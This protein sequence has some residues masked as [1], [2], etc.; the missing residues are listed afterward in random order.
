MLSTL[1][2]LAY[3]DVP[4]VSVPDAGMRIAPGDTAVLRAILSNVDAP[5][6][7]FALTYEAPRFL[8][9]V[10]PIAE[11]SLEAG[12]VRAL[13]LPVRIDASAPPGPTALGVTM[14]PPSGESV[15]WEIPFTVGERTSGRLDVG[16]VPSEPIFDVFEAVV[17]VRNEGNVRTAFEVQAS[18]VR[19]I[20]LFLEPSRLVLEPDES[21][22]VRMRGRRGGRS[23][24]G[25]VVYPWLYLFEAGSDTPIDKKRLSIQY[26][27]PRVA[28]TSGTPFH[29]LPLEARVSTSVEGAM[30]GAGMRAGVPSA[31]EMSVRLEGP[32]RD[33]GSSHLRVA[34]RVPSSGTP[35][36]SARFRGAVEVALGL[37][38][39][40]QIA[41]RTATIGGRGARL[42]VPILPDVA[43]NNV[44]TAA[45]YQRDGSGAFGAAIQLGEDRTQSAWSTKV[46]LT[47]GS[48][49]NSFGGG[50]MFST[51]RADRKFS[52]RAR[53]GRR[54]DVDAPFSV[55]RVEASLAN[56]GTR[57]RTD[58]VWDVEDE[59]ENGEN[60]MER[61]RTRTHA[62]SYVLAWVPRLPVIPW[63]AGSPDVMVAYED[64][65]QRRS[66]GWVERTLRWRTDVDFVFEMWSLGA[67]VERSEERSNETPQRRD[68]VG[69]AGA[70]LDYEQSWGRAE[71][72]A[73]YERKTD[74]FGVRRRDAFVGMSLR[75][76]EL[77]DRV[78]MS[79]SGRLKVRLPHPSC[80][81]DC[82][83]ER[84]VRLRTALQ[85]FGGTVGF[86]V[87]SPRDASLRVDASYGYATT[88]R[89]F[90]R[91]PID[92]S[93]AGGDR[94]LDTV[95]ADVRGTLNSR[96]GRLDLSGG[97]RHER[98]GAAS[99]T[100]TARAGWSY[101]TDVPVSYRSDLGR[102]E[103]RILG[104]DG[105]PLP[106]VVVR[107][108]ERELVT[109]ENG[110]FGSDV[111]PVGP[112]TVFVDTT[113]I[114]SGMLVAPDPVQN[115]V[116]ASGE[117]V[118]LAFQLVE[119]TG[120]RGR[121][122]YDEPPTDVVEDVV[123]GTGQRDL[124]PQVVG[125]RTIIVRNDARSYRTT[126]E[127]DGT[128]ELDRMYPGTYRVEVVDD[129]DLQFFRVE[130]ETLTVEVHGTEPTPVE[131]RIVPE[132]RTVEIEE[133]PGLSFP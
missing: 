44:I 43:G 28:E 80:R 21:T 71:A 74:G 67:F 113:R 87:R 55:G 30:T 124:D 12:E 15:D 88:F 53:G 56:R 77:A 9:N 123:F 117:P 52:L 65:E 133:R 91:L 26:A 24:E 105:A 31:P 7:S 41:P 64:L 98:D 13:T 121:L 82:S 61:R 73:G 66:D 1:F 2:T 78:D 122:V 42:A 27:G 18:D 25:L 58:W 84:D 62:R 129:A 126:S 35:S 14:T 95:S 81:N 17:H 103:G 83:F 54:A 39:S 94:W 32:L 79:L 120:V 118:E 60:A 69:R 37:P 19:G 86:G 101:R 68:F 130:P 45:A 5:A 92:V 108:D 107:V 125:G 72:R 46:G 97:V 109:D 34:L 57:M 4:L 85:L 63:D 76:L 10:A 47:H 6:T 49:G 8:R 116:L 104:P 75:G 51:E 112:A 131:A 33:R 38:G 119:A 59:D 99:T 20:D 40:T 16:E 106:D 132:R 23:D 48:D 22:V 50:A 90:G 29:S 127:P 115:V 93:V 100:F 111:L 110:T 3:A 128:F 96:F 114:P 36:F 89:P 11:L 70:S 102:L